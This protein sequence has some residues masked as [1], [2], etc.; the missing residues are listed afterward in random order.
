MFIHMLKKDV[1]DLRKQL[2]NYIKKYKGEKI[3]ISKYNKIIG[4]I[5]FYTDKEKESIMLEI[6]KEIIKNNNSKNQLN[7]FS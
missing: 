6:A 2:S 4:E 3:Y 1:R 7:L 5:R